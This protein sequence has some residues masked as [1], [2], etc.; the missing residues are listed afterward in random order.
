MLSITPKVLKQR[1][2]KAM[3]EILKSVESMINLRNEKGYTNY[4]MEFTD[5]TEEVVEYMAEELRK[6]GFS[7]VVTT[8]SLARYKLCIQWDQR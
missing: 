6:A 3:Q 2:Q 8:I 1:R 4:D 7:V 5:T